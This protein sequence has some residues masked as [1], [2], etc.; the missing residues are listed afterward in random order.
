MW[1]QR[2][3]RGSP[4][5]DRAGTDLAKKEELDFPNTEHQE[6]HA[7]FHTLPGSDTQGQRLSPTRGRRVA[8]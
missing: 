2:Q 7:M 1:K 6:H 5:Q 4:H 8:D 3:T